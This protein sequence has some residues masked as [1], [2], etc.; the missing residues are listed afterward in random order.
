MAQAE[1]PSQAYPARSFT[2]IGF[3]SVPG[4]LGFSEAG[5]TQWKN[6]LADL[7]ALRADAITPPAFNQT[8][9]APPTIGAVILTGG[10]TQ[11]FVDE[12]APGNFQASIE[13]IIEGGTSDGTNEDLSVSAMDSALEKVSGISPDPVQMF[14]ILSPAIS[15]LMDRLLSQIVAS[16]GFNQLPWQ[17]V[18]R[19]VSD[20]AIAINGSQADNIQVGNLFDVSTL[21]VQDP[22]VYQS[23]AVVQVVKVP[24]SSSELTQCAY[25]G[26]PASPAKVGD[27]VFIREVPNDAHR[28]LQEYP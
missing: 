11:I 17:S 23:V 27:A 21:I 5:L 14:K 13:M 2:V 4:N 28:I 19:T 25:Y 10:I 3:K 9:L 20:N 1:T 6:L 22:P 26:D 8:P 18:V 12:T 24:A 15:R 7:L 16:A